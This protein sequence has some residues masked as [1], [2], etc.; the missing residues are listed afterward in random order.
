VEAMIARRTLRSSDEFTQPMQVIAT[1]R[2]G[3]VYEYFAE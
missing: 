2:K 1:N 3:G